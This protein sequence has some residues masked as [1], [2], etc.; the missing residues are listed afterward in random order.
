MANVF[1]IPQWML[2][3]IRHRISIRAYD[4]SHRDRFENCLLIE[5]NTERRDNLIASVEFCVGDSRLLK[6]IARNHDVIF[7]WLYGKR[8]IALLVGLTSC[9]RFLVSDKSH[10]D[11]L[12][13]SGP[14]G[15]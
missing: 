5:I 7:A 15:A 4:Y 14:V 2:E 1:E 3:K 6:Y 11:T 13:W 8:E 10:D 9:R 12:H